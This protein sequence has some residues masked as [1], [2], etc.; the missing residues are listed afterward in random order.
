M[1]SVAAPNDFQTDLL[2]AACFR[3]LGQVDRWSQGLQAAQ[4]KGSPPEFLRMERT[5]GGIA[6]GELTERFQTE[7]GSLFESGASAADVAEAFLR[8]Y[9]SRGSHCAGTSA[10][11]RVYVAGAG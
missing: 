5:L 9:L 7:M 3:Q 1:V 2:A 11:R 4:A 10:V 8:G 6:S